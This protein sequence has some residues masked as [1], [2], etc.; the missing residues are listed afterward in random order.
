MEIQA[1]FKS[2][3]KNEAVKS[4]NYWLTNVNVK[5]PHRS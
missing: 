1:R 2:I 5:Q 3:F 4:L